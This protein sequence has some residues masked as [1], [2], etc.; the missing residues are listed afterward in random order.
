[1]FTFRLNLFSAAQVENDLNHN[2]LGKLKVYINR[3]VDS[4]PGIYSLSFTA[5]LNYVFWNMIKTVHIC[6]FLR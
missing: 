2:N 5:Y 4:L 3:S 6:C 1:M